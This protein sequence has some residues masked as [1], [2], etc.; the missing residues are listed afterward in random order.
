MTNSSS[1]QVQPVDRVW[2]GGGHEHPLREEGS[3]LCYSEPQIGGTEYIRATRKYFCSCGGALT[4]E[5]YITH[6][7]ELGHD[8][9]LE[10][11]K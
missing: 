3:C 1:R 4:A 9:G 5:E 11:R 7:F 8:H 2:I 6:Y 10:I